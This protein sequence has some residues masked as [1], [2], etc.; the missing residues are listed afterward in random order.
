MVAASSFAWFVS[1]FVFEPETFDARTGAVRAAHWPG[2]E[3]PLQ[4]WREAAFPEEDLL[5]HV[6]RH[7]NPPAGTPPTARLWEVDGDAL[8]SPRGLGAGGGVEWALRWKN[9][10]VPFRLEGAELALFRVG[11]GLLTVQAR[12]LPGQVDNWLDFL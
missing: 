12:P 3:R 9:R 4:V 7:L 11:V 8:Q 1:P 5:P 2:R 6:A 10:E